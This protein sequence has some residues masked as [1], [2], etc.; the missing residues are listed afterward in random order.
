ML[1]VL[2][3]I[4]LIT[5]TFLYTKLPYITLMLYLVLLVEF[6]SLF[7]FVLVRVFQVQVKSQGA[8]PF[9]L[10]LLFDSE[11]QVLISRLKSGSPIQRL[12]TRGLSFFLSMV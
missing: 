10:Q 7:A 8:Y 4:N 9:R 2:K 12:A 1:A 5:E 11:Q 6:P 3:H